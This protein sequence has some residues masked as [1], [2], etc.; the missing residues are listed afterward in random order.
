MFIKEILLEKT[1]AGG[2]P[3][4]LPAVRALRDRRGLRLR[5]PV[6]LLAGDNG[7]GKSTLIEAIAVAAGFNPEGGSTSFNFA[8][9]SS[10]SSL[11]EHLVLSRV[12]GRRPR[13]GYFLRAE[14]FYN[15]ATE[16]ERL[17]VVDGYGGVSPHQRSHGESFLDLAA[18]RFGPSGLYLLDE[19]EAA[20]S[21][22][23]CLALLVRIAELVALGSQFIV[24][25][26][27]PVLLACRDAAIFE[28]AADGGISEIGYDQADAV[29]LTRAFLADPDRFLDRMLTD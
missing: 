3:F 19:P 13:T 8:T 22:Q 23:G 16:I 7:T 26:H 27:S 15:V 29:V 9:R 25:T 24:A 12:P 18:H 17:G 21:V 6:T 4:D 20:L 2:Y 1:Q 11:G 10:E 5:T 14:S 28:I